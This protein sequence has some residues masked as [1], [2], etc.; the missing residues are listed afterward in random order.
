MTAIALESEMR[1]GSSSRSFSATRA[2][3]TT[4]RYYEPKRPRAEEALQEAMSEEAVGEKAAVGRH[5]G[6]KTTRLAGSGLK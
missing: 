1:E 6:T 4:Q 2:L 3:E 5:R